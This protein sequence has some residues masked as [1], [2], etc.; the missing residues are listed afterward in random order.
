MICVPL[1]S[2]PFTFRDRDTDNNGSLEICICISMLG[3][4]RRER[5]I[6]V[7]WTAF[8]D[9]LGKRWQTSRIKD[10]ADSFGTG[11]LSYWLAR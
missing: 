3:P 4:D 6:R 11:Q 1:L 7:D 9:T 10:L 8:S 5:L 2:C